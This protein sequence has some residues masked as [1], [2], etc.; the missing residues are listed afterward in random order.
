MI[1]KATLLTLPLALILLN[2]LFITKLLDFSEIYPFNRLAVGNILTLNI[3]S[4]KD[5]SKYKSEIIEIEQE[6]VNK[7][8]LFSL[9]RKYRDRRELNVSFK[10]N[11]IISKRTIKREDLNRY[12]IGFLL[13]LI[14]F[15]NIHYLW[16][17]LT[18]V[19]NPNIH[20]SRLYYKSSFLYSLFYFSLV[21]LYSF[22]DFQLFILVIFLLLGYH[23]ILIGFNLSNQKISKTILITLLILAIILS[24]LTLIDYSHPIKL[25]LYSCL[26]LY[27]I[28]CSIMS[29]LKLFFSTRR[30]RDPYINSRNNLSIWSLFLGFLIPVTIFLLSFYSDSISTVYPSISLTIVIPL[31][32]G[33]GVLQYDR[34]HYYGYKVF[35]IKDL[36][37]VIIYCITAIIITIFINSSSSSFAFTLHS[38]LYYSIIII[39][40]FLILNIMLLFS[41]KANSISSNNQ[42]SFINSMQNIAELVSSPEDL[43]SKMR[44]IFLE[45]VR[46]TNTTSSKL[47]L[48]KDSLDKYYDHLE[49]YIENLCEGSYLANFF[50]MNREIII[51]YQ[52]I[53][54]TSLEGNIF[55]FLDE[56]NIVI[57]VPVYE[58]KEIRAALMIGKKGT[59][60]LFSNEEINYLKAVVTQLYQLIENDRLYR[61]YIIKRNYER[62]LDNASYVQLRL[63]PKMAPKKGRGLDISFY[64][65]PYLR[66]IGDY[67]DFFNVDSNRTAIIIGDVSGHGLSAAMIL[68]AINSITYAMIREK[69][70]LEMTFEEINF[71]L[72]NSFKGIELMALFVGIYDKT[73]NELAYINAGHPSPI[74]L[75][76]DKKDLQ[77]IEGRSKVLGADPN[78]NYSSSICTFNKNDELILYT[79]GAVEIYND[80][81]GYELNE[82]K[83]LNIIA[84]NFEQNVDQKIIELEKN[85]NLYSDAIR[86]DITIIGVK[87]H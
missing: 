30:D 68:S 58:G 71:F 36:R 79:D 57:V 70:S 14:L 21:D 3:N 65:R 59:D 2:I 19:I 24:I 17:Y 22:R 75:K 62:E 31:L 37:L 4:D 26:F 29:I 72:N 87:I 64:Y 54:N 86:D 16:A 81:K 56:R 78:A 82:E 66:V 52:L 34:H 41:K 23:V 47:I 7:N 76:R 63:F 80:E 43:S 28:F 40:L 60:E 73:K 77:L 1:R 18:I 15:A 12:Y 53:K 55:R 10:S 20:V 13:F 27:L 35:K 49:G 9:L 67:F 85:I 42:E 38:P 50:D 45:I 44:K 11:G 25:L 61:D 33:N 48:F 74:L 39:F 8:N 6:P 32:I 84:E 69:K 83:F 46:L 51:K 5:N